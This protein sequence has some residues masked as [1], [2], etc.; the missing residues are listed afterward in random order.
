[1]WSQYR[2]FFSLYNLT[3]AFKSSLFSLSFFLS[4][5]LSLS[6]TH[7]HT[8]THIKDL[9]S[10]GVWA[11]IGTKKPSLIRA[12]TGR[13]WSR[14]SPHISGILSVVAHL[15]A[16]YCD[17]AAWS[18]QPALNVDMQ[19]EIIKPQLTGLNRCKT[20]SRQAAVLTENLDVLNLKSHEMKK[21][22]SVLVPCVSDCIVLLS[23]FILHIYSICQRC[24][25]A[26]F[27]SK[28]LHFPALLW[29][30]TP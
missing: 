23:F 18:P 1:M 8:G 6:H 17:Q 21:F 30:Q 27:I 3:R 25:F 29:C 14:R 2:M 28:S 9:V 7:T 5:S 11:W 24:T 22:L 16:I 12:C 15:E 10:Y 19:A 13:A 4:L 20:T 26:H